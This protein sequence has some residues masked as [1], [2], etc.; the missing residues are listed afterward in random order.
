MNRIGIGL[1]FFM[2]LDQIIKDP[3]IC[4]TCGRPF[5][6]REKHETNDEERTRMIEMYHNF[7]TPKNWW[8]CNH[9]RIC[10]RTFTFCFTMGIVSAEVFSAEFLAHILLWISVVTMV[11]WLIT[12]LLRKQWDRKKAIE[13]CDIRPDKAHLFNPGH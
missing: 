11:T 1:K 6:L 7:F 13:F 8:L 12:T 3:S 2:W 4:P 10:R 5:P 9:A